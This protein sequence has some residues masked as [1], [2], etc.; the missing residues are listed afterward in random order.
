VREWHN[1]LH[2]GMRSPGEALAA[3]QDATDAMFRAVAGVKGSDMSVQAVRG[4]WTDFPV[5]ACPSWLQAVLDDVRA[6]LAALDEAHEEIGALNDDL[7]SRH[8]GRDAAR[9]IHEFV[10]TERDRAWERIEELEEELKNTRV[11]KEDAER[12]ARI[13]SHERNQAIDAAAKIQKEKDAAVRALMARP[14][15]ILVTEKQMKKIK[16][17]GLADDDPRD[18]NI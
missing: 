9:R 11:L 3:Q 6:L 18:P 12:V 2:D 7:A 10:Q 15:Q 5:G 1:R 17:K 13:A 4:R 14:P 16:K 8:T